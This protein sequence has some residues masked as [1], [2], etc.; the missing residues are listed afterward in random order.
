MEGQSTHFAGFG[1]KGK[2]ALAAVG[3]MV[4]AGSLDWAR[5]RLEGEC[6]GALGE[7][8]RVLAAVAVSTLHSVVSGHC[9]TSDGVI[10]LLLSLPNAVLTLGGAL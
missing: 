4:L 5:A 9:G 10:H 2:G 8:I 6:C 7:T 1:A 3:M